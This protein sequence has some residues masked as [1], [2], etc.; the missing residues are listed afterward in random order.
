MWAKVQRGRQFV[1]ED[2]S[3]PPQCFASVQSEHFE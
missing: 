3:R 1:P 2:V